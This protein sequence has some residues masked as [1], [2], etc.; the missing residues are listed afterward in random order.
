MLLKY[1]R[2]LL[3]LLVQ[4]HVPLTTSSIVEGVLSSDQLAV[5]HLCEYYDKRI[6]AL[7]E[8]MENLNADMRNQID[9]LIQEKIHHKQCQADIR[10]INRNEDDDD[11]DT[12]FSL[13]K[14]Q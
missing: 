12:D 5:E 14:Q 13:Q 3:V 7:T 6:D 9:K 8:K 10:K 1:C 4:S 2:I 11:D